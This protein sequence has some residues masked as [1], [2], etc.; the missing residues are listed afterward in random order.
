MIVTR[1]DG[2]D[3]SQIYLTYHSTDTYEK[4]LA[5]IMAQYP[6]S[7]YWGTRVPYTSN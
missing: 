3:Y 7:A 5:Q 1:R 6:G 4:S 2:S